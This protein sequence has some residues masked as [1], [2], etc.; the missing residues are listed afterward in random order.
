MTVSST[1]RTA[2]PFTG[3][4]SQTDF[5]FTMR[6]FRGA[7]IVATETN[8]SDIVTTLVLGSDY[9]VQ[10]NDNQRD[11]PGGTLT[12]LSA[13]TTGHILNLTTAIEATQGP[14]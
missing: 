2:G 12:M 14:G 13:L 1:T 8:T 9:T 5:A 10:V 3:N 11:N 7:D 6:V 4:G